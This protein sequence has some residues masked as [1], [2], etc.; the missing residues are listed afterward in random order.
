MS[1]MKVECMAEA[2]QTCSSPVKYEK[3]RSPPV[4]RLNSARSST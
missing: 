4:E 3:N 2:I 1:E